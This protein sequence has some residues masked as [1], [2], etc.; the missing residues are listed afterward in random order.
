MK[1]KIFFSALSQINILL[2]KTDKHPW[3]LRKTHSKFLK[4]CTMKNTQMIEPRLH[5]ILRARHRT[6]PG[7]STHISSSVL[8]YVY[9]LEIFGAGGGVNKTMKELD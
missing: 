3:S 7:V 8:L 1:T 2:F 4:K 6:N 5:I 9:L